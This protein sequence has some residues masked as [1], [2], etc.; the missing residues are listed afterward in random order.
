MTVIA[1]QTTF[2]LQDSD[3][4]KKSLIISALAASLLT[5]GSQVFAEDQQPAAVGPLMTQQEIQ[6]Y[7][8]KMRN[9]QTSEERQQIQKQHSDQIQKRAQARSEAQ[10]KMYEDSVNSRDA[11]MDRG[12]GMDS[13]KGKGEGQGGKGH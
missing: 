12:T 4:I 11:D 10:R 8:D 1:R 13:G 2:F 6:V 9:A 5:F 7:Q 3:M